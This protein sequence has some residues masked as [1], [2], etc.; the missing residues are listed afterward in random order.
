[1]PP[2]GASIGTTSIILDNVAFKNVINRVY[3]TEDV[4]YVQG[5]KAWVDTWALGATYLAPPKRGFTVGSETTAARLASLTGG[6][7]GMQIQGLNKTPFFEKAKP[8]YEALS[9]KD[10]ISMKDFA[11]G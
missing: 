2:T 9:S 11:K 4:E 10:F 5:N 6:V 7:S 8:Q 3:S 1:M